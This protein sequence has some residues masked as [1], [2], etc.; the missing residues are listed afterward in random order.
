MRNRIATGAG[1]GAGFRRATRFMQRHRGVT[2]TVA[3]TLAFLM[4]FSTLGANV[5]SIVRLL[6]AKATNYGANG[7]TVSNPKYFY[8]DLTLYDYYT[9]NEIYHGVGNDNNKYDGQNRNSIFNTA[10]L[11]SGYTGLAGTWGHLNFFPLYLGLQFSEQV[12]GN[13]GNQMITDGTGSYKYSLI[14]NSESGSTPSGAFLNLVKNYRNSDHQ[15]VQG[16]GNV[17][18]VLPYFDKTFL[19]STVGDL[20]SSKTL[21]KKNLS[22]NQKIGAYEEGFKF[23]FRKD[24]D[25][26][27][28]Y[29]SY[30][31][32]WHDTATPGTTYNRY[33]GLTYDAGSKTYKVVDGSRDT[34][35]EDINKTNNNE[36]HHPGFFPYHYQSGSYN[37][38]QNF[39]Y[40]AK[41]EIPFTMT[42]NGCMLIKDTQGN[43]TGL[44]DT[45][46]KFEFSGDDD[47]WVFVDDFLVLDVGGAHGKV[48]G[49][50]NFRYD[51]ANSIYPTSVTDVYKTNN[52]YAT[53]YKTYQDHSSYHTP[54]S[55]NYY[56]DVS[57][58]YDTNGINLYGDGSRQHTLTVYYLERG[59]LESNCEISFNLQVSDSLEVKNTYDDTNVGE[60]FKKAAKKAAD[61]EAVQ[62]VM[63]SDSRT[64]VIDSPDLDVI[65]N[66]PIQRDTYYTVK[67]DTKESSTGTDHGSFDDVEVKAGD[68][69][70]LPA[71]GTT[72]DGH[73]LKGWDLSPGRDSS[74]PLKGTYTPTAA[75]VNVD[76]E[77]TLYAVYEEIPPAPVDAP[78]PPILL[79]GKVKTDNS[80]SLNHVNKSDYTVDNCFVVNMTSLI[81]PDSGWGNYV[82]LNLPS[83]QRGSHPNSGTLSIPDNLKPYIYKN[84]AN[85]DFAYYPGYYYWEIGCD[86]SSNIS[87]TISGYSYYN[88]SANYFDSGHKAWVE[89]YFSLYN[90][91]KDFQ[92]DYGLSQNQSVIETYNSWV[93]TYKEMK[94]TGNGY[95]AI[96]T[97]KGQIDGY[98]AT[99]SST[100]YAYSAD[101]VT[102][103]VH[104][105]T[106]VAPTVDSDN[107]YNGGNDYSDGNPEHKS[108][109][110]MA[111]VAA[112]DVPDGANPATGY[113]WSVTVP[114]YVNKT[115]AAVDVTNTEHLANNLVI[116]GA[117][118]TSLNVTAEDIEACAGDGYPCWYADTGEQ[119]GIT[120]NPTYEY[121]TP[122]VFWVYTTA[123]SA[124]TITNVNPYTGNDGYSTAMTHDTGDPDGYYYAKMYTKVTKK[125]GDTVRGN[126]DA[127]LKVNSVT[128][129]I[130]DISGDAPCYFIT[131]SN[132][133]WY[134]LA[135]AVV[136]V[137]KW[138]TDPNKTWWSQMRLYVEKGSASPLA[139]TH[140]LSESPCTDI[141]MVSVGGYTGI[142]LHLCSRCVGREISVCQKKR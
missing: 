124:P 47:V 135:T 18:V 97:L 61:K 98:V 10:L 5:S 9:D 141:Y 109:G 107:N 12:K 27:Y 92:A 136:Q 39:G 72:Y 137:P 36:D 26:Y 89:Q 128:T 13:F 11:E 29:I 142:L 8:A 4:V 85:L 114:K 104:T 120:E 38:K 30:N 57:A 6:E 130:S 108:F 20:L 79:Y 42:S 101:T 73:R 14:A 125:V 75:Q 16:N 51:P 93:N 126:R 81:S 50:I 94:Y 41:F 24:S 63:A 83:G 21:G 45:P 82:E 78:P 80:T 139:S 69:V 37:N 40:G 67:F 66:K 100:S 103:Y 62:Y 84:G 113:Y 65:I 99:N 55:T 76:N 22:P 43:V 60:Y 88:S 54:T 71:T 106:N 111:A 129:S 46:M 127:S 7:Y 115:T 138:G 118:S 112:E 134:N 96:T 2:R 68:S 117:D 133:G 64:S 140:E 53:D 90:K 91:L 33:D 25:G 105:T 132:A 3:V 52:G 32:A 116:S 131:T 56:K 122:K 123:G 121:N 17:E 19:D 119:R 58:L 86:S 74:S 77:V 23:G 110:S 28:R 35:R 87:S 49:S 70:T 31:S 15:I 59:S 44:S 1:T 95:S 48:S 34:I 102:F